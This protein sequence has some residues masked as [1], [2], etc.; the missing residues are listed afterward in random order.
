[1][2]KIVFIYIDKKPLLKKN[3]T[4]DN[5]PEKLTLPTFKKGKHGIT[6]SELRL[7]VVA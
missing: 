6:T 3:P 7:R 1:M 5:S 2:K 4:F